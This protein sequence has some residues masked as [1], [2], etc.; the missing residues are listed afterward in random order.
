M[1]VSERFKQLVKIYAGM[2]IEFPQLRVA[3]V[4]QWILESGRGESKLFMELNNPFGMKYRDEMAAYGT[5]QKYQANDGEDTYVHF[6][7][8]EKAIEGYWRFIERTPYNGWR[9]HVSTPEAYI[10]YIKKCGYAEDPGY[11]AKVTALFP[12][13]QALLNEFVPA[14]EVTWFERNRNDRGETIIVGYDAA[15]TQKVLCTSDDIAT[16]RKFE[17]QYPKAKT[18]KVA[19]AGKAVLPGLPD[20]T[21]GD[22]GPIDPPPPPP[23]GPSGK[24]V[25]LDPGH[26]ERHTGAR[27]LNSSV[28]EEDLNRYQAELMKK[29]LAALGVQADIID[30]IDDDLFAIGA[31]SKGYDAFLSL[32]LNAYSNKEHY[33][34][35]MC[36]S[37]RQKPTDKSALVA[38]KFAQAVAAA[39]GNPCFSGTAG[40]PKGVMAT[41]L[42]VLSGAASVSCP[43]FFLSELE[44]VDDETETG[45]I[46]TR[47][48]KGIKAGAKVLAD[49]LGAA[50]PQPDPQPRPEGGTR[51]HLV[52]KKQKDT[53]GNEVLA[54]SLCPVGSATPIETLHVVSG[55]PSHQNFRL[56]TDPLC[57]P[58]NYE[59]LPQG[60]YTLGKVEWA[61]GVTGNYSGSH[62]EGLGPVWIALSKTFTGTARDSFG[63]HLD[64]NRTNAPGSAGCVTTT[65]L[66][67]L[68]K[69]VAW[70]SLPNAPK[71]LTVDWGL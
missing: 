54:L 22:V 45:P 64:E 28:Q 65:N 39:I 31:A 4:A 29:E 61:S 40:W 11:V 12:E 33:T 42:S 63:I 21:R 46:K 24:K 55:G 37:S 69:V 2:T 52:R 6:T 8:L 57:V 35:T 5:P 26:S 58:K 10:T 18:S 53:Y 9:N 34:C 67:D 60:K 7:S 30:P 71:E 44:F 32:H 51:L 25:L 38:S 17:D 48:E 14:T 20:Y 47:I 3:T 13:A 68:K 70:M 56:P 16:Q 59:P 41:G 1:A 36:H 19:P 49:A 66:T 27:G 15:N 23:P 62:G 50:A 43:I